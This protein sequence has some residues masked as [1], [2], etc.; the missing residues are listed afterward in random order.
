MTIEERLELIKGIL[1]I[2]EG[3]ELK[4]TTLISELKDWDSLT[5]LEIV[6]IMEDEFNK[7]LPSETIKNFNSI[8]DILD[9]ME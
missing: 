3:G 1:E 6:I 8:K 2:K 7:K 4:E 5:Q 9:Y